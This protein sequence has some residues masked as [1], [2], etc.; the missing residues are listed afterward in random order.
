MIHSFCIKTNNQKVI[1]ALLEKFEDIYSD[2]IFLSCNKFKIYK[3]I[4]IHYTGENCTKFYEIL[5]SILTSTIIEFYEDNLFRNIIN[6][7]YF[8]FTLQEKLDILQSCKKNAIENFD[9]NIRKNKIYEQCLSYIRNNKS[10]IL[11]GFITFRLKEYRDLLDNIVDYSINN[12]LVQ[13]EYLE[14]IELLRLYVNSKAPNIDLLHLVYLENSAI[15]LD[16]EKNIIPIENSIANTRFLSDISFSG[17]DY[18]L[19]TILTLIPAELCIHLVDKEDEFIN[20]LKLV[21]EG[22]V[23]ICHSCD[24]CDIMSKTHLHNFK[25]R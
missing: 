13:R 2:N 3:N 7:N 10:V 14:F 5:S 1:D 19:N 15:L 9:I 12:F 6:T 17:N 18:C 16:K 21:F 11:D 20:T 24:I 23:N 22:R 8:Y 4:I 25:L